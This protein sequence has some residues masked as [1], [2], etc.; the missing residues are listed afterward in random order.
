MTKLDSAVPQPI[1]RTLGHVHRRAHSVVVTAHAVERFSRI[2]WLSRGRS[3]L[4]P[5]PMSFRAAKPITADD[6]SLCDRLLVA[7]HS[8]S[9]E[10]PPQEGMWVTSVFQKRQQT[11]LEALHSHDRRELARV[12]ASMFRSDIVVGM[13]AGSFGLNNLWAGTRWFWTTQIS[14]QLVSLAESQ[15]V[16]RT[17][18]PEQ[19]DVGIAFAD[20][21]SPIV[22]ALEQ[23]LGGRSL[24][25]PEVGSAY[26]IDIDGRLITPDWPDQIYGAVRLREAIRL[27]LPDAGAARR[28]VVEI[29]GGYGGMAYWF[30]RLTDATITVIDLPVVN[31]LQGYFLAQALGHDKVSLYQEAPNGVTVL[32]TH[33]LDAIAP[34]FDVLANKDSMPE[35]PRPALDDYLQWSRQSCQGIL[36]SYNQEAAAIFD[37]TPQNVV[38]EF[39]ETVGGYTLIRRDPS[40]MRSGYV[41]EI[42]RISGT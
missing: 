3:A 16:V 34:G 8:A 39:V 23:A 22:A 2:R 21:L 15:G 42:Y 13:A 36:Y 4:P 6:L 38:S 14:E 20:G 17:E 18:N 11:L 37:G 9:T 35:I 27:F 29:G 24:D 40:W 10:V 7:Y 33:A 28:R 30:T 26:G 41:E 5:T 12:L 25:F 19:G 32:P 31:V 1:R